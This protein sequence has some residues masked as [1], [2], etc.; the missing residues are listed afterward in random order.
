M[1]KSGRNSV[2]AWAGDLQHHST[3]SHDS[4]IADTTGSDYS[5]TGWDLPRPVVFCV[6]LKAEDIFY[7]FPEVELIPENRII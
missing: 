4:I 1:S 6:A 5:P 2:R 3:P 7:K